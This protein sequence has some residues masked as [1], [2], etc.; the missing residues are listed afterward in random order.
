MH[1]A[2]RVA[3][4]SCDKLDAGS[5]NTHFQKR[6]GGGHA[7]RQ[8]PLAESSYY[9]MKVCALF[10]GIEEAGRHFV[11][12]LLLPDNISISSQEIGAELRG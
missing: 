11:R 4:S 10:G 2:P 3:G 8:P 12:R 5:I 7:H 6:W 1:A 9:P